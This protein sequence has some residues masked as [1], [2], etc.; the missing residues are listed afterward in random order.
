MKLIWN[1]RNLFEIYSK[2]IRLL[3]GIYFK[4]SELICTIANIF[5]INDGYGSVISD[6]LLTE[7]YRSRLQK[8]NLIDRTREHKRILQVTTNSNLNN[9]SFLL[10]IAFNFIFTTCATTTTRSLAS[11]FTMLIYQIYLIFHPSLQCGGWILLLKFT[12][13]VFHRLHRAVY[14]FPKSKVLNQFIWSQ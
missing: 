8:R 11:N 7:I 3:F 4:N 9:P 1:S 14:H 6:C 10:I 5:C 13:T 2:F 12:D